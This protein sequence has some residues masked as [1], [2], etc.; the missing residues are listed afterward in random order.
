M[1][2]EAK[3]REL[4]GMIVDRR[5]E[6]SSTSYEL[7]VREVAATLAA[8]REGEREAGWRAGVEAAAQ[9][10]AK[11]RVVSKVGRVIRG[12]IA[13]EIRALPYAP[14]GG[15]QPAALRRE[16]GTADHIADCPHHWE[17]GLGNDARCICPPD[18][19]TPFSDALRRGGQ[20]D[21]AVVARARRYIEPVFT[22][23][24]LE[25]K[26]DPA[27]AALDF[28]RALLAALADRDHWREAR[29]AAMEAGEIL[30]QRAEAAE[31]RLMVAATAE[32]PAA[33]LLLAEE[34]KRA[35]A[36]EARVA[37]QAREIAR[38]R[39]G[40]REDLA[41]HEQQVV[42]WSD[43]EGGDPDEAAHHQRRVCALRAA[44]EAGR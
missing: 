5:I 13:A 16:P 25:A 14:S 18:H 42:A 15:G 43:P 33:K 24:D 9:A 27:E 3:A 36:A 7:A 32:F 2:D 19:P 21:E 37:E 4:L 31:R 34:R 12:A 20:P 39:V 44:L 28:A 40:L 26:D 38:L 8:E 30:R 17:L 1:S 10:A 23:A 6:T 11:R 41:Y 22:P 29:R 35:E